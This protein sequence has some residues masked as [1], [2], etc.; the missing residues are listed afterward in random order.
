MYQVGIYTLRD[1]TKRKIRI[2][3]WMTLQDE[4]EKVGITESDIFQMQLVI[5]DNKI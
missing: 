4:L 3:E 2:E 1:G 5:Q